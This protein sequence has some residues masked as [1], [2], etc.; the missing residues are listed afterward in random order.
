[1]QKTPW[2]NPKS[3]SRSFPY[4][5]STRGGEKGGGA[6]QRRDSSSEGVDDVGE[7]TTVTLMCGSLAR[8]AGVGQTSCAC[9]EARGR[10]GSRPNHG[11]IAQSSELGS[12]M[13]GQGSRRRKELKNGS[14]GS[15]VYARWRVAEV[16]RG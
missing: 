11:G 9:G 13:G 16:Q 4:W 12:F 3:N 5:N 2:G 6:Y 10:R 7:V 14:P 1:M 8:M 15:P